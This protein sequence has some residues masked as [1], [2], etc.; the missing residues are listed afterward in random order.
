[1]PIPGLPNVTMEEKRF[2]QGDALQAEVSAFAEAVRTG[3]PPPVTGEDG[4]RA[5]NNFV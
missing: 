1:M 4:K 5:R 3:S 2:E